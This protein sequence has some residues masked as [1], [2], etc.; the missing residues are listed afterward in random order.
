MT[1]RFAKVL[2]LTVAV[3]LTQQGFAQESP[4]AQATRKK[5]KQKIT[6]EFKDIGTKTVF[7]DIKGEMD[8]PCA[9]KIR[10]ET[11]VSNNTKLTYKAKDKAVQQILNELSDKYEFGWYVL[12][13]PK[14]RLDGW[15]IIRK[16]S[17]GKER[18][19]EAGKEPKEKTSELAPHSER[20]ILFLKESRS[21]PVTEGAMESPPSNVPPEII[22]HALRWLRKRSE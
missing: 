13:D 20:A 2:A 16:N 19:Y 8:K 9:F 22:Q 3:V 5:L 4:S 6:V 12:S 18:G 21:H 7:D 15:V 14:D 17:K 10:N 11:G 1:P